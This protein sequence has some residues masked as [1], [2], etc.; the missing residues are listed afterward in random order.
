[1]SELKAN[2]S[3]LSQVTSGDKSSDLDE[4]EQSVVYSALRKRG[5]RS[6][7]ADLNIMWNTQLQALWKNVEGSQK[8][9]PAVPGRHIIRDSPHW[10]EL[11]AATWKARRAIHIFLLNDYLLVA[12]RKRKRADPAL[13][14]AEGAGQNQ[15]PSLSKLVAEH[16]WPLHDI[17]IVDLSSKS[18][19][20]SPEVT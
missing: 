13:E 3:A 6:S 18:E 5:D 14:G 15:Q 8:F 16:C 17:E 10:V 4:P 19:D 11:N 20:L 2:T 7:V 12:T 1:M 9:L